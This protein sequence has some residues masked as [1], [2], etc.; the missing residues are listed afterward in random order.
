MGLC[1][2]SEPSCRKQMLLELVVVTQLPQQDEVMLNIT[3]NKGFWPLLLSQWIVLFLLFL[4]SLHL[5]FIL[6]PQH[7]PHSSS[8]SL[9]DPFINPPLQHS[10]FILNLTSTC[11]LLHLLPLSLLFF[12]GRASEP[13]RF[14]EFNVRPSHKFWSSQ[15]INYSIRGK[16]REERRKR[17]RWWWMHK[18]AGREILD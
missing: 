4:F 2:C 18:E 6:P 13:V 5:P 9:L 7:L 1:V 3:N 11:P 17:G 12:P 14:G 8:P 10:H 16:K 15:L